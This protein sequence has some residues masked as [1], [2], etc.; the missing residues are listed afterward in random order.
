MLKK[1]FMLNKLAFEPFINMNYQKNSKHNMYDKSE[2]DLPYV[3]NVVESVE[4]FNKNT[5]IWAKNNV[6]F[7]ETSNNLKKQQ[8]YSLDIGKINIM[9][10]SENYNF[11]N[12]IVIRKN[13]FAS[14]DKMQINSINTNFNSEK[15][16]KNKSNKTENKDILQELSDNLEFL[17]RRGVYLK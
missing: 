15:D 10:K 3:E 8:D 1:L 2:M 6:N 14:D 12:E 17:S 4:R 5:S 9:P 11:D 13:V 16:K 7:D